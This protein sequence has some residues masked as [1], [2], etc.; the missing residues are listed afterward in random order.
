[1]HG[2]HRVVTNQGEGGATVCPTT[3]VA[4]RGTSLSTERSLPARGV[5]FPIPFG[6]LGN[7]RFFLGTQF[8]ARQPVEPAG[9]LVRSDLPDHVREAALGPNRGGDTDRYLDGAG[10]KL[11]LMCQLK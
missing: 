8:L 6:V 11:R 2:T 5:Q 7:V 3:D 9:N 1:M 10:R 4:I